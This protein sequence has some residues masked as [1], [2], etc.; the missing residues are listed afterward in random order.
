M[1]GGSRILTVFD[2]EFSD[3]FTDP[4]PVQ[5]LKKTRSKTIFVT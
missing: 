5:L 3:L 1:A 2:N 4:Y